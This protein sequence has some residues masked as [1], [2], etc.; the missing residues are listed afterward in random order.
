MTVLEPGDADRQAHLTCSY[1]NGYE[2]YISESVLRRLNLP[3]KADGKVDLVLLKKNSRKSEFRRFTVRPDDDIEA[4]VVIG[5]PDRKNNSALGIPPR[6]Q[7]IS[8]SDT[9]TD[10]IDIATAVGLAFQNQMKNPNLN[11]EEFRRL[12]TKIATALRRS[13]V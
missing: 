1:S 13:L 8:E 11:T 5:I 6:E 4:D 7:A 10:E 2:N 12:A 9:Q 3:L